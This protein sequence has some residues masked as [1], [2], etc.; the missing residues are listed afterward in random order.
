VWAVFIII[1]GAADTINTLYEVFFEANAKHVIPTAIRS[2][3]WAPVAYRAASRQ[4]LRP[5]WFWIAVGTLGGLLAMVP[6]WERGREWKSK[7]R[8]VLGWLACI[9]FLSWSASVVSR[10]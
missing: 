8:Q 9:V 2:W 1:L 5:R 6:I 7:T 10:P 3:I 4:D